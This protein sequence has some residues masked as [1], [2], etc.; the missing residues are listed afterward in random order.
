MAGVDQTSQIEPCERVCRVVQRSTSEF[1]TDLE[2]D[3]KGDLTDV[4]FG[5]QA[6]LQ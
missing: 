4:P 3:T 5:V 6:G 1:I 2:T